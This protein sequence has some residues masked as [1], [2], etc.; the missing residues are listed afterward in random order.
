M[1]H[2]TTNNEWLKVDILVHWEE[3]KVSVYVGG[4]AMPVSAPMAQA[5]FVDRTSVATSA[6][7]IG[8]YSLTPGGTC[9]I[10][11]LQV[12]D[13]ACSGKADTI[14]QVMGAL[15]LASSAAMATSAALAYLLF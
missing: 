5:F 12:C 1:I 13:T 6:N 3:Q 2:K 15:N 10:K 4:K 7:A 8:I 14:V 11:N 9:H